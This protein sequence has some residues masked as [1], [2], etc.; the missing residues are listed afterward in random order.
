MRTIRESERISLTECKKI[1]NKNGNKYT[2]SEIIEI[3][4]WL[5]YISEIALRVLEAKQEK[6]KL[7]SGKP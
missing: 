7:N 1:L 6:D 3:R 5:Y 4:N 2:D